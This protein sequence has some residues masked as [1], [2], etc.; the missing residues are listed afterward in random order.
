M[1]D[2][3]GEF[4]DFLKAYGHT[5]SL[6]ALDTDSATEARVNAVFNRHKDTFDSW[7]KCPGWLKDKYHGKIPY[8]ILV[9]AASDPNFTENDALKADMEHEKKGNPYSLMPDELADN[10]NIK[11]LLDCG[12]KMTAAHIAV[13]KSMADT[14]KRGGYSYQ[15]AQKIGTEYAVR[16]AAL[17]EAEKIKNSDLPQD[18]KDE[19]LK[20]LYDL[21]AKSRQ[22]E[23]NTKNDELQYHPE[24]AAVRL[25]WQMQKDHLNPQE[26]SYKMGALVS[27]VAESGNLVLLA[28]QMNGSKYQKV[29]RGET[30]EF[31][32]GI[33]KANGID[34][35]Y[36]KQMQKELSGRQDTNQQK[37]NPYIQQALLQRAMFSR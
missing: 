5:S 7:I 31:F 3:G 22:S 23:L 12:V 29:I 1:A 32:D 30:K 17:D 19:K 24:K 37:Q 13:M 10:E 21:H 15:N 9:K 26:V 18:Q 2:F 34:P 16:K 27:K 20:R 4:L 33:L 25:L 11:A 36:V 35:A 14:Y 6:N 8:D 28:E